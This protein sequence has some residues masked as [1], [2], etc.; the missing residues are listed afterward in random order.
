MSC[1]TEDMLNSQRGVDS[2]SEDNIH[3]ECIRLK[4]VPLLFTQLHSELWRE[5]TERYVDV[6]ENVRRQKRL[7]K[8]TTDMLI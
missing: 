8:E 4:H 5:L 3:P 7:S 1:T 6:Q 2:I